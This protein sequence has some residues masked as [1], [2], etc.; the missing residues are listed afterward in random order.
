MK[1]SKSKT[2]SFGLL[3]F[4]LISFNGFLISCGLS[5]AGER[6][7]L[8]D[9]KTKCLIIMDSFTWKCQSIESKSTRDHDD[10]EVKKEICKFLTMSRYETNKQCSINSSFLID[11]FVVHSLHSL[12]MIESSLSCHEWVSFLVV[13]SRRI[14]IISCCVYEKKRMSKKVKH[15]K[16][17]SNLYPSRTSWKMSFVHANMCTI[18]KSQ[19]SRIVNRPLLVVMLNEIKWEKRSR[20]RIFGKWI[21]RL[22]MRNLFSVNFFLPIQFH[23]IG[24]AK[25]ES[26]FCVGEFFW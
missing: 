3:L 5:I 19:N 4:I 18:T 25:L 23:S 1:H 14:I 24:I 26:F 11:C 21:S 6:G 17:G 15:Q 8:I 2:S 16:Y 22:N 12:L 13:S 10:S 9:S 7:E 20:L